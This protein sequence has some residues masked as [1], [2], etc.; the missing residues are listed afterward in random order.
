M[1]TTK[2]SAATAALLAAG[3]IACA[4]AGASGPSYPVYAHTPSNNITCK[5]QNHGAGWTL[6]CSAA[7][8]GRT[9]RI[10]ARHAFVASYAPLGLRGPTMLYGHRYW[11]G[12]FRCDS[13]VNA[14]TCVLPPSRLGAPAGFQI[15]RQ[16]GYVYDNDDWGW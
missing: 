13:G 8:P 6:V 2:L 3:A 11:L 12:P 15:S 16:A 4:G 10:A 5:A 1:R 14:L 9:L 7:D